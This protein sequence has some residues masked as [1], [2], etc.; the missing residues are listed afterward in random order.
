MS[1]NVNQRMKAIKSGLPAYM[2][3]S[4][5]GGI[6]AK[7]IPMSNYINRR[8]FVTDKSL[9]PCTNQLSGVGRYKSQFSV[10]ADSSNK[11]ICKDKSENK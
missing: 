7:G 9:V 4:N 11:N 8:T 10:T 5:V 2:V 1:G 3:G 6:G